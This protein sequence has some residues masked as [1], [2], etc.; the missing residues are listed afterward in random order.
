MLGYTRLFQ[1][2]RWHDHALAAG[3]KAI[4][5]CPNRG[6]YHMATMFYGYCGHFRENR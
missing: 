2:L 5:L 6:A 3:E 1:R 4:A